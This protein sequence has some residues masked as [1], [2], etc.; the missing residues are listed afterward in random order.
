M[1]AISTSSKLKMVQ[2]T[3]R[4]KRSSK[5]V[6]ISLLC[7][8]T[9]QIV[10]ALKVKWGLDP[11]VFFVSRFPPDTRKGVQLNRLTVE[12]LGCFS[13][14]SNRRFNRRRVTSSDVWIYNRKIINLTQLIHEF[15]PS[16]SEH[17][18]RWSLHSRKI[19]PTN[20]KSVVQ[21]SFFPKQ[22]KMSK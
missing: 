10:K 16:S 4:K 8:V 6:H 22:A 18:S 1:Q 7:T 5:I 11:N 9:S 19:S 13:A 14:E 2:R 12:E 20:L 17:F 21:H 3:L 15:G